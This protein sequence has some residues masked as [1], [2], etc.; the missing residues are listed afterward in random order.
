VTKLASFDL[1]LAVSETGRFKTISDLLAYARANPGKLNVGTPQIGT[2]QNLAAELFAS[3]AGL[4]IQIVPFNGTPP[5]INAL[6]GGEIDAM[7]DTKINLSRSVRTICRSGC[8]ETAR[9]VRKGHTAET[10]NRYLK[11][12][13]TKEPAFHIMHSALCCSRLPIFCFFQLSR[14]GL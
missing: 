9:S 4:S 10:E 13:F 11:S 3:T 5:V 6:R 2:T 7:V 14:P 1:V 8:A 12:A